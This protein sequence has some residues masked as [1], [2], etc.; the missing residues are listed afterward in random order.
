MIMLKDLPFKGF[1]EKLFGPILNPYLGYFENLKI[2][3]RK[4]GMKH[5]LQD[6]LSTIVFY[7]FLTFLVSLILTSVFV[8]F[9]VGLYSRT[10]S[11]TDVVYSYTLAIILS[12]IFSG[13]VFFIGYTYPVLKAKT[14]KIMIERSLPFAVFYMATSASSGVMPVEIFKMLSVRGGVIGKEAGR[15]YSDVTTLGMNL[16]DALQR[17]A[18]RSPSPL[19]SDLLWGMVS[20]ITTGGDMQ[21][22]LSSKTRTFMNHYRLALEEY[23]KQ[24]SLYT[25]IYITL[26]IVG[27][28]F[29]IVLISIIAPMTGGS[30]TLLI[31]TFLVF[32]FIPLVSTEFIFLLK[33]ISPTE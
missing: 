5:R 4:A 21:E 12:F 27:S 15:I 20:T 23:A 17:A 31:Q 32:F 29:F 13:I 1:A 9:Y 30:A 8:S 14:L 33:A 6:Y 25:E 19:F 3:M 11:L 2:N 28:L 22:Y 24:I 18:L 26:I 16:S 7:S 10:M